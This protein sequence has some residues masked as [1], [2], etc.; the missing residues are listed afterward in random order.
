MV[1]S[2]ELDYPYLMVPPP[3]GLLLGR[4]MLW[5]GSS[6]DGIGFQDGRRVIGR[7]F[8]NWSILPLIPSETHMESQDFTT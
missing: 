8:S 2:H 7:S 1:Q 6:A 5:W 3:F 4:R